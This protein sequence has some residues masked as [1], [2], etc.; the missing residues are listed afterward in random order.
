MTDS[1]RC[2]GGLGG[3]DL[4]DDDLVEPEV[5]HEGVLSIRRKSCPVRVRGLLS[6][7]NDL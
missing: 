4:V 5:G 3:V 1:V 6:A 7:L 2:D